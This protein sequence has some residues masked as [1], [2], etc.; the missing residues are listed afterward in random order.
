M[1]NAALPEV[2]YA[3]H[4][5]LVVALRGK[6]DAALG[7]AVTTTLRIVGGAIEPP[8]AV[9]RAGGSLIVENASIYTHHPYVTDGGFDFTSLVSGAP[10]PEMTLEDTGELMIRDHRWPHV[11]A[12][13]IVVAGA[14]FS[15]VDEDGM[16]R[17]DEVPVGTYDMQV[18]F[19]GYLV[20]EEPVEV[21]DTPRDLKF[22]IELTEFVP[23]P[24]PVDEEPASAPAPA[25][26]D[27]DDDDGADE[28]DGEDPDDSG[29]EP[30]DDGAEDAPE[31]EDEGG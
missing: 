15:E 18:Y 23:P 6:G 20:H 14:L 17:F 16:A 30:A 24:E 19:R 7:S 11:R 27:D 21:P 2:Y 4:E 12:R 28:D 1:W 8:V 29:E 3:T 26:E 5:D 13:V 9:V 25:D 31:G 10:S 22:P